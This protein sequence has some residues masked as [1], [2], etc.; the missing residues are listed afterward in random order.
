MRAEPHGTAA[1]WTEH[2]FRRLDRRL[3]ASI[4]G[5]ERAVD[6]DWHSVTSAGDQG[7]HPGPDTA[8]RVL[9]SWVEAK[10]RRCRELQTPLSEIILCRSSGG[11]TCI[12]P[13][14]ECCFGAFGAGAFGVGHAPVLSAQSR[15]SIGARSAP[16]TSSSKC[17]D[18]LDLLA[19][20]VT[21]DQDLAIN[22]GRD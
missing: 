16:Q 22:G 18:D 9:Q 21:A 14:R 4:A 2:H 5:K 1:A 8:G 11:G 20:G 7:D 19:V 12:V 13:D 15:L 10:A 17:Q 3:S 6:R